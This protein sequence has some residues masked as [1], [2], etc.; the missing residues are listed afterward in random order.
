VGVFLAVAVFVIATSFQ[1]AARFGGS[2]TWV[3]GGMFLGGIGAASWYVGLLP[4]GVAVGVVVG[5][6]AS[7]VMSAFFR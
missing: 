6:V 7:I 4:V 1:A 5:C 3:V 2:R